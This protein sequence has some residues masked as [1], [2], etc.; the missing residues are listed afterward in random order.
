MNNEDQRTFL[1][2]MLKVMIRELIVYRGF[3]ENLR[4]SGSQAEAVDDFLAKMRS[5]PSIK[6]QLG[7]DFER[8]VVAALQSGETDAGLILRAFLEGWTSQSDSN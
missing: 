1:I 3:V 6:T 8:F 5:D 7:P 4:G 2:N